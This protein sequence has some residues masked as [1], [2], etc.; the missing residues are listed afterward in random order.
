MCIFR[1][2]AGELHEQYSTW[3]PIKRD[4]RARISWKHCWK[5]EQSSCQWETDLGI[6][7]ECGTQGDMDRQGSSLWLTFFQENVRINSHEML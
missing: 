7:V 4:Q 1:R 2:I 5:G 3:L 6:G